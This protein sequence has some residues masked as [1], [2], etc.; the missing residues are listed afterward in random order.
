MPKG[1]STYETRLA[2]AEAK[3]NGLLERL[4]TLESMVCAAGSSRPGTVEYRSA[5]DKWPT[6]GNQKEPLSP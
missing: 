4:A 3:I 6:H 5:F 1:H 2:A